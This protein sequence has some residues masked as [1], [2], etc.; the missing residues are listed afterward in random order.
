[1]GTLSGTISLQTPQT[2]TTGSA[3]VTVTWTISITPEFCESCKER[4]A[5]S[6]SSYLCPS[7]CPAVEQHIPPWTWGF[8]SHDWAMSPEVILTSWTALENCS[9]T[10]SY[11]SS[12]E[13]VF[14][15]GIFVVR[16][17]KR[18]LKWAQWLQMST[19][20]TSK[21]RVVG[22]WPSPSWSGFSL[23]KVRLPRMRC[24]GWCNRGSRIGQC[25]NS[26]KMWV[27]RMIYI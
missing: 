18:K 1:M 24:E 21:Q 25:Q 6:G 11:K 2:W 12:W 14:F 3:S 5:A 27:E 13:V 26:E 19:R 20:P 8:P 4:T 17:K 23:D 10:E 22:A 9:P 7:F 16:C 15:Q